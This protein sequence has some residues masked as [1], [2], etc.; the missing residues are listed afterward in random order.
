MYVR[1]EECLKCNRENTRMIS[2]EQGILLST[3]TSTSGSVCDSPTTALADSENYNTSGTDK[4]QSVRDCNTGDRRS[5]A[6]TQ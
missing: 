6:V 3:I 4:N 5:E 1:P 2:V